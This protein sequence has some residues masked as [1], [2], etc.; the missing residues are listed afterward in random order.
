MR[1]APLIVTHVRCGGC[2]VTLH[3]WVIANLF[4]LFLLAFSIP[5]YAQNL[6]LKDCLNIAFSENLERL[7]QRE[8]THAQSDRTAAH[9][10]ELFP[11][12]SLNTTLSESLKKSNHAAPDE[13]HS[14]SLSIKQ[15][16]Y[17]GSR[18]WNT[19]KQSGV[20][21]KKTQWL[22]KRQLQRLAKD[23]TITWYALL[24]AKLLKV[25]AEKALERLQKHL[26]NTQHF[27]REGRIW[28][29][30]VLQAQ[31]EV[32][33]GEQDVIISDNHVV[34]TSARLNQLLHRS[35]MASI[36]TRDVLQWQPLAWTFDAAV[37]YAKQHH[38][39]LIL[40]RL[41]SDIS[42]YTEDIIAADM[43][44]QIDMATTFTWQSNELWPNKTN[45]DANV[46]LTLN[47]K[48]W[49]W[50]KTRKRVSAAKAET[51]S[52]VLV[53]KDL[54]AKT[55]LAIHTA[56][57]S[58]VES[59]KRINVLKQALAQAKENYRVNQIRYR[60]Q[61]GTANDVLQA[62]TLLAKMQS[63]YVTA[64]QNY[65]TA[66]AEVDYAIGKEILPVN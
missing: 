58:I 37:D 63:D 66:L 61:L 11:S 50:E 25:E 45:E 4:S 55:V 10:L 19:F 18:L 5:V 27:F 14:L 40:A 22:E 47:W 31:V 64:I 15:P 42:R 7:S 29:N 36:E 48:L 62:Q 44:P 12:V 39:E 32:A 33:R 51:R 21:F 23:V 53:Y 46:M 30:E 35:I 56:F 1:I 38:P 41:N 65:L 8:L 26:N 60:E 2:G 52:E 43:R 28:R 59:E 6:T 16:I 9:Y 34:L 49:D 24:E 3:C 20:S 17:N 57:L 13:N 54:E